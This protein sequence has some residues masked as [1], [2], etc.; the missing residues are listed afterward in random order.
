MGDPVPMIETGGLP[1]DP[2]DTQVNCYGACCGASSSKAH[3][4]CP[5]G[6]EFYPAVSGHSGF[7]KDVPDWSIMDRVVIPEDLEEGDYLL[8]WRWDCEESTQ[9]W[10][11]CADI[12]LT[13]DV[14]PPTTTPVPSPSPTPSPKPPS[15]KPSLTCKKFENPQCGPF[16]KGCAYGGCQECEDEETYNCNTCCPGCEMASKGDI[17]YCTESS[18]IV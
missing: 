16:T 2:W 11:N 13:K 6:T 17:N 10:Q 8:S 18:A 7:G 1:S 14:P 3:G 12:T 9:V 15:P 4:V 5:E